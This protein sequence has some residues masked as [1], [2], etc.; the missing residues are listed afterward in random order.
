MT[1]TTDGNREILYEEEITNKL[2][3]IIPTTVSEGNEAGGKSSGL[4]K[5]SFMQI[6]LLLMFSYSLWL[7]NLVA[8]V[9]T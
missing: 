8:S 5:P 2:K 4:I 1:I 6:I 3:L 7:L 9:E